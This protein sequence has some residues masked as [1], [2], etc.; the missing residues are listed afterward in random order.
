MGQNRTNLVIC[1]APLTA[2]ARRG[3]S[4]IDGCIPAG[5][6]VHSDRVKVRGPKLALIVLVSAGLQPVCAQIPDWLPT[7]SI[8]L[9]RDC[10]EVAD[11]ASRW[12][13]HHAVQVDGPAE[14]LSQRVC[15]YSL[16]MLK[17][18]SRH[19][20]P[21]FNFNGRYVSGGR[22][23]SFLS[24]PHVSGGRGEMQLIRKSPNSCILSF[25]NF[26]FH[27]EIAYNESYSREGY[28]ITNF[29]P[30]SGPEAPSNHRLERE[31][32]AGLTDAMVR[33]K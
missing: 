24:A 25:A 14:C 10:G 28:S 33:H 3:C 21:V 11:V 12:L 32:A 16:T 1:P 8:A 23:H 5:A 15:S 22:W 30:T 4:P 29:I 2:K 7:V 19:R 18:R 9:G 27:T 26:V 31:Y 17:M 13:Q 20:L 6:A